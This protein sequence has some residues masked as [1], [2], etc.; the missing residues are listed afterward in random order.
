MIVGFQEVIDFQP[1]YIKGNLQ[2]ARPN[3]SI[4]TVK[5][6]LGKHS[7]RTMTQLDVARLLDQSEM[8]THCINEIKRVMLEKNLIQPDLFIFPASLGVKIGRRRSNNF[9]LS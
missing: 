1:T 8:R 7:Q 4:D 2:K 9:L 6:Q 5:I 3:L